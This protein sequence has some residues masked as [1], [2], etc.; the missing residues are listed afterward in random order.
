[1]NQLKNKDVIV[2]LN[3]AI[4][5]L[6]YARSPGLCAVIKKGV[7]IVFLHDTEETVIWI[8]DLIMTSDILVNTS[9]KHGANT[10]LTYWWERENHAIRIIVLKDII[11]YLESLDEDDD[12]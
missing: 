6:P 12:F 8:K 10:K 4:E 1:M 5:E 7:I 9:I 2:I 11:K 3:N